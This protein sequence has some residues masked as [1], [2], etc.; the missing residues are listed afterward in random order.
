MKIE[1]VEK[2][3]AKLH[4]KKENVIHISNLK[5]SLNHKLVLKKVHKVIKFN[6]EVCLKPYITFVKNAKD[7]FKKDFFKLMYNTVSGKPEAGSG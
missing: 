5:Q 4:D 7:N 2:L 3:A 6:Q 1:K